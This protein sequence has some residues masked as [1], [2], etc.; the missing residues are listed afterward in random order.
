M[1]TAT[2]AFD[3]YRHRGVT[4]FVQSAVVIDNE[5]EF[6]SRPVDPPVSGPAMR[7]GGS[8]L[9]RA[10]DQTPAG[11]IAVE[12]RDINA[13]DAETSHQLNAKALTDA[14]SDREVICGLYRPEP[15][16]EMVRRAL[17]AAVHADIVILDWFLENGS[18]VRAKEI[19]CEILKADHAGNGRL[20]LIA[21][22]TSQT[23]VSAIA[24]EIL[25]TVEEVPELRGSLTREGSVLTGQNVRIRVLSKPQTIGSAD[26]DKVTESSL[27][28]R[29]IEEF[30]ELSKGLLTSF[31]LHSIA[32]VRRATHHVVTV[33]RDEL[34][35]AYLGHRCAL[36]QPD[37][38]RDFAVELLVGELRNVV[39]V[40]ENVQ[41]R[42]TE[43]VLDAW[44]DQRAQAGFKAQGKSMPIESVKKLLRGGVKALDDAKDQFVTGDGNAMGGKLHPENMGSLFFDTP[45]A[46]WNSH[47]EL[48]RVSSF[49]REAFGRTQLP[50]DFR[51]TLSLGS[52]LKL[53][54]PVNEAEMPMYA[55]LSAQFYV[56]MQPRCDSVRLDKSQGFPFQTAAPSSGGFNL[57]VKERGQDSGTPLMMAG[58]LADVVIVPF[59]PDA[60]TRTVRAEL[61]DDGS[62]VFTDDHHRKFV[63]LGDMRDLKAQQDASSLAASVHRVGLD[64]LEWLRLAARKKIAF[65]PPDA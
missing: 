18:S 39:A 57:V 40:D 54:G 42:M 10:S 32:A 35:G 37:D 9:G 34:D 61:Q 5:A 49:K 2:N 51:P 56:C 46:A 62:F 13:A 3:S 16:E 21:V 15:G 24:A 25:Q 52:V 20:R 38:A 14:W 48:S 65:R 63:W 64:E 50:T 19:A 41:G 31:A 47:L 44:V 33:F 29:L 12:A 26:V 43:A 8:I 6:S 4:R 23:G 11:T 22:Y 60:G 53:L 59:T 17:N 30:S 36:L 45:A 28:Q 1:N 55:G 7:A 58:K 27:P